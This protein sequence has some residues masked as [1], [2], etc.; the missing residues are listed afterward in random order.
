M[1]AANTIEYRNRRMTLDDYVT[2][3]SR[4]TGRRDQQSLDDFAQDW[5]DRWAAEGEAPCRMWP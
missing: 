2:T 1:T 5:S 4:E 3:R